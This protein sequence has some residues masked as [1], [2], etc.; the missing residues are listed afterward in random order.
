MQREKL[1]KLQRTIVGRLGKKERI[2]LLRKK[3]LIFATSKI[4]LSEFRS[5]SKQKSITIK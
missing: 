4:G 3:H 2:H 5:F 1:Y